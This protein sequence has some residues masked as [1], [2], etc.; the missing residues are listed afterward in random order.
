MILEN[1]YE[2]GHQHKL[3]FVLLPAE[4]AMCIHKRDHMLPKLHHL[5]EVT[6]LKNGRAALR[7]LTYVQQQEQLETPS[8]SAVPMLL[9]PGLRKVVMR[10]LAG[11]EVQYE[12]LPFG[13][14]QEVFGTCIHNAGHMWLKP[15]HLHEA[16]FR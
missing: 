8:R 2:Q 15:D 11:E 12:N 14:R 13:L 16:M 7:G 10:P 3:K 5:P 6:L 4:Q 1:G 9:K